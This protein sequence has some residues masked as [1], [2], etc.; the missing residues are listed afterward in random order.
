MSDN[1]I[2]VTI[3]NGTDTSNVANI[4]DDEIMGIIFP[5]LTAADITFLVATDINNTF[6]TVQKADL[7]GEYIIS[8]TTGD[9]AVWTPELAPFRLLKIKSS[10]DQGADR[11]IEIQ[12]R[13][14]S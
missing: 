5:T 4:A 14:N 2:T 10:V 13:K 8:A 12:I 6:Q 11:V 3:A 1:I 7:S 9:I